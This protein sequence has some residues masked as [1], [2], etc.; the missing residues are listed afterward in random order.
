MALTVHL[1]AYGGILSCIPMSGLQ[2][3]R[4]LSFQAVAFTELYSVG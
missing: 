3:F 2:C 4:F 1:N